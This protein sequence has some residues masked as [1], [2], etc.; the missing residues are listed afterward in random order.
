M[1]T[2]R[3]NEILEAANASE[4]SLISRKG[5][6]HKGGRLTGYFLDYPIARAKDGTETSI[7]WALAE[8]LAS[9]R[10]T[11]VLI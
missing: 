11:R 10:S 8:R 9:G 6:E 4:F 1:T 2:D 7:S 5:R 3:R